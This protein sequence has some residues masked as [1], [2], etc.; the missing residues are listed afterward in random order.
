MV[1]LDDIKP[2]RPKVVHRV[3]NWYGKYERPISSLSLIGGFVFDALTLHRVDKFWENMWVFGHIVIVAIAMALVHKVEEE[4]GSE[5]N[6]ERA[7][8][9]LVN[10]VQFFF[11]GLLST[12]LVF[13]F[14]SSDISVSWPFILILALAFW[15][16]ESLKRYFVR[17]SFQVALLYLSIFSTAIFVMPIILHRLNAL[18]FVTSGVVSL[19]VI[20]IFLK[21]I[22]RVNKL[23]FNL[24][25]RAIFLS[26]G[27]I[28][29]GVN[30]LY[31]A[32]LIPPIPLAL[33][34][35]G[36]YHSIKKE[37]A[38]NYTGVTEKQKWFSFLKF[39]DDMHYAPG[40]PLYVY[41]AIFSPESLNIVVIHNWQYYKPETDEWVDFGNVR[42]SVVGG[43][44]EGFRTYSVK[45]N[46]FAGKWRVNVETE[47]GQ[48]IGLVRFN[49]I[50]DG[51]KPTLETKILE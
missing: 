47:R 32:N 12:F 44:E 23:E 49:L 34:D 25:K 38:G 19:I 9:W 48:V 27:T 26:I 15:A 46:L 20:A 24:N 40:N 50:N 51:T 31:F 22:E 3:R 39:S 8:F 33:K 43:R 4:P 45:S 30:L 10:V 41:S 29:I 5:A 6:P 28:F 16:N 21:T 7:R 1:M 13:Y 18:V 42:L 14:R 2:P 11:G 36:I 17:L 37:S 35:S